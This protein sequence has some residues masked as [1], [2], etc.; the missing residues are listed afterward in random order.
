MTVSSVAAISWCIVVGLVAFDEVGLVAVA[1]EE[2]FQFLVA[3][4]RQDGRTGDL[5][6]VEVQD[7]QHGAVARPD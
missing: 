5:V 4:A 7:R 6:A 2:R 3:D 1:A